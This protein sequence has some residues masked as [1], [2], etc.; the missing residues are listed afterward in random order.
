MLI[1]F[2]GFSVDI[3]I[4]G[5]PHFSLMASYHFVSISV[6]SP[7][8][9]TTNAIRSLFSCLFFFLNDCTL[10][11]SSLEN[12]SAISSSS[13]FQVFLLKE[14][15][16][17]GSKGFKYVIVFLNIDCWPCVMGY[18]QKTE[19]HWKGWLKRYSRGLERQLGLQSC[20]KKRSTN[21]RIFRRRFSLWCHC[22][23][24]CVLKSQTE[25]IKVVFHY[26]MMSAVQ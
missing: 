17:C 20:R 23:A 21:E 19:I 4:F 3:L 13:L 2:V 18:W 1:F 11:I 12:P 22:R 10:L 8:A 25:K 24:S 9:L 16:F 7:S 15:L 6:R 14:L 26:P 5:A